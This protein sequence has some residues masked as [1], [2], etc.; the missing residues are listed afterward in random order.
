MLK[1][2]QRN[3]YGDTL[4]NGPKSSWLGYSLLPEGKSNK[5]LL[6]LITL[7]FS[8]WVPASLHW[9]PRVWHQPLSGQGWSNQRIL[10]ELA[11]CCIQCQ[12]KFLLF[13]FEWS[14]N[15]CLTGSWFCN[16][17]CKCSWPYNLHLSEQENSALVFAPV[18]ND[19]LMHW[20]ICNRCFKWYIGA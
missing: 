3:G 11:P 9:K 17:F 2:I 19:T 16:N 1:A 6:K 14:S 12:F 18:L 13:Y 5:K 8:T 15:L 4:L 20:C 7:R 10:E